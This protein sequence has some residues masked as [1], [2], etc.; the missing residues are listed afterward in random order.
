MVRAI[1]FKNYEKVEDIFG[2]LPHFFYNS[3]PPPAPLSEMF[4][5]TWNALPLPY[6]TFS[7]DEPLAP[8]FYNLPDF[9]LVHLHGI[10]LTCQWYYTPQYLPSSLPPSI[11]LA[12]LDFCAAASKL[13]PKIIGNSSSR[14][15]VS[16]SPIS[17]RSYHGWWIRYV[18]LLHQYLRCCHNQ[19]TV[20]LSI[21]NVIVWMK[22]R[23]ASEVKLGLND[24]A[25]ILNTMVSLWQTLME[26]DKFVI[27]YINI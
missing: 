17:V 1:P 15:G 24:G 14:I 4:C 22:Y 20:V 16:E 27:Y 7:P 2:P 25:C 11:L 3:G 23:F 6:P 8:R 19:P 26:W 21:P 9:V 12:I 13:Y 10:A 5:N 18:A